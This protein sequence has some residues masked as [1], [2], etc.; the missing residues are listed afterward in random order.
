MQKLNYLIYRL[1]YRYSRILKLKTPVDIALELSSF[2]NLSCPY[3]Y[4]ADK[5]TPFPK[6]FMSVGIARQI[7]T[8]AYH[9]GVPS[10]KFNWR[11]ESI[12][13]PYFRFILTLAESYSERKPGQAFIDRILNTNMN[14]Q[15][16]HTDIFKGMQTLTKL[17]VSLDSFDSVVYEKQR[18]GGRLD[19][20]LRNLDI[21]MQNYNLKTKIVI[22]AVRTNLN[23]NEDI[24]GEVKKRWPGAAV[25]IRDCVD[26][27]TGNSD[28]LANK[29][30]YKQRIPCLQ[31]Y[32]RLIF[33]GNGNAFPCCPV[34]NNKTN[35]RL[36]LGNIKWDTV[37]EIFNSDKAIALRKG[38]KTGLKF[39]IEPCKSC[40]S[41]ESYKG[42]KPNWDS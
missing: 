16:N 12:S 3:C 30:P 42:Y 34:Y 19:I 41:L 13:N 40:S 32:S 18:R 39:S 8:S 17:K 21:F 29:T 27:R 15:E 25:S 10:I 1:K 9:A 38:L 5:H 11:G 20:V 2:C 23:A 36:L 6:K 22:Q 33:D 4:H 24:K 31:A 26:G 7:L 14:F 37:E 35:T 28:N